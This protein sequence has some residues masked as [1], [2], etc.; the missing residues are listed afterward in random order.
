MSKLWLLSLGLLW[1]GTHA[2]QAAPLSWCAV[3]DPARTRNPSTA[4]TPC[5]TPADPQTF[6]DRLALPLPCFGYMLMSK[7]VVS[8]K[9]VLD[10][11]K[12]YLGSPPPDQ[13]NNAITGLIEGP[14]VASL[15]GSFNQGEGP[16]DPKKPVDL[17]RL[18]GRSYY[19]ALYP[20]TQPQASR[21]QAIKEVGADPPAASCQKISDAISAA[22]PGEVRPITALSWFDANELLRLYQ[23]WLLARDRAAIA[24]HRAPAL[25]WEQGSPAYLR[26]PTEAE[27]EYAARGGAAA[28]QDQGMRLYKV[29]DQRTGKT[30]EPDIEEIAPLRDSS[31]PDSQSPLL[32]TRLPNRLGLYD[33]LGNVEQI[34][35]DPFRLTRPDELHG[36]AGGYIVRGAHYLISRDKIDVGHRREMPYFDSNGETRGEL[37]GVRFALSVPVFVG[38][39]SPNPNLRYV[40]DLQNR[41]QSEALEAA[42]RQLTVNTPTDPD[43]GQANAKVTELLAQANSLDQQKLRQQ[44]DAIKTD[45]DRSNAKLD[46]AAEAARRETLEGAV[47]LAVNVRALRHSSETNRLLT[48]MLTSKTKACRLGPEDLGFRLDWLARIRDRIGELEAVVHPTYNYYLSRLQDLARLPEDQRNAAADAVAR[49]FRSRGLAQYEEFEN[50]VVRQTTTLATSRNAL[51][52]KLRST[53]SQEIYDAL[54]KEPPK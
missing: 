15:A 53:W 18:N 36:Q 3:D 37:V 49:A 39:V 24:A 38:G 50:V 54:K 14:Q 8:A 32:G 25:P 52:D 45:L 27:W 12:V 47:L 34:T 13:L 44:L 51:S 17:S 33:L 1:A 20:L 31:N 30:R 48:D 4:T 23:T 26:L 42:Q 10:S 28:Q 29:V 43:R 22:R 21:I 40:A 2:V 35:L 11:Q 7:V 9:N 19:V 41:P 5:P 16:R 6:P 46:V